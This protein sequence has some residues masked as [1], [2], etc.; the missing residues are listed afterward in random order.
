[1]CR[2]LSNVR[3]ACQQA[4]HVHLWGLGG[5]GAYSGNLRV[6]PGGEYRNSYVPTT[7][8]P[9]ADLPTDHGRIGKPGHELQPDL[10]L[11]RVRIAAIYR[12]KDSNWVEST[13]RHEHLGSV[14]GGVILKKFILNNCSSWHPEANH[15]NLTSR[16]MTA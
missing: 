5:L 2:P 13:I 15:K 10:Q 12:L 4:Q 9:H 14:V 6:F 1:M 8:R 11:V 16:S 7:S 3:H